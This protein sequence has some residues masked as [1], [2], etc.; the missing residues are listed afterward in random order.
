[1][2]NYKSFGADYSTPKGV[3]TTE[4]CSEEERKNHVAQNNKE[5]SLLS[6]QTVYIP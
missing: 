2:L 1:M 5:K 6:R 4:I 3:K